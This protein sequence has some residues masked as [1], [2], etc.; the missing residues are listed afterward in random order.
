MLWAGAWHE[1]QA[2]PDA[3]FTP[4]LQ[5]AKCSHR[6][7]WEVPGGRRLWASQTCYHLAL[8]PSPVSSAPCTFLQ[9]PPCISHRGLRTRCFLCPEGPTPRLFLGNPTHSSR[10]AW[11]ESPPVC[12][13]PWSSQP[14]KSVYALLRAS[15]LSGNGGVIY[16]FRAFSDTLGKSVK[17]TRRFG[18]LLTNI[19]YPS[20]LEFCL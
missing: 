17:L 13:L 10:P 11:E 8:V 3:V 2:R 16:L 6:S 18:E 5:C 9:T 12:S 20:P 14:G 7:P 1:T 15:V 19:S 4:L